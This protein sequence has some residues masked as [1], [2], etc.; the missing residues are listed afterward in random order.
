VLEKKQIFFNISFQVFMSM[1]GRWKL[2]FISGTQNYKKKHEASKGYQST[3][4]QMRN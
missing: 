1:R 3:R 4:L 2:G